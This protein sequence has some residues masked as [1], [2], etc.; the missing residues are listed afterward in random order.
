M[1]TPVRSVPHGA[2][3]SAWRCDV[4]RYVNNG[5]TTGVVKTTSAP[6][7]VSSLAQYAPAIPSVR[8]TT[9]RSS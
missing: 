2:A 9:R 3:L 6:R 5:P 4:R 1:P 7:S 8:S